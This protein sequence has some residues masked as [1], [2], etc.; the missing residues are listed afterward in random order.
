MTTATGEEKQAGYYNQIYGRGYDTERYYPIYE[1]L[2]KMIMKYDAPRV[3]ELGCG[4]GDLAKML[5]EK[6]V[7]YRGFDFSEE[8]VRQSQKRVP[9]GNFCVG[10]VYDA[11]FYK[12]QD[13][14]CCLAVE[15]L[16]HVEDLEVIRNIPAGVR[17]VASV[18]NYDD[19]AHLRVY[20]DPKKDIIERFHPLLHVTEVI[21]AAGEL[22]PDGFQ[23]QIH[24]F[25]AIRLKD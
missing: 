23:P 2:A 20:T 10:N 7:E 16:E 4:I 18:P 11:E 8:A 19:P 3:L 24:L 25:H 5:I 9:T 21:S 12:P 22:Q 17:L 6:G 15:V 1:Q 14:T 13:Y